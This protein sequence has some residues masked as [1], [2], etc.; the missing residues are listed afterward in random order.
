MRGS[1][2]GLC[3]CLVVAVDSVSFNLPTGARK[4]LSE[5]M[6]VNTL[7]M[8]GYSITPLDAANAQDSVVDV[9]LQDPLGTILYQKDSA[10]NGKFS[11]TSTREGSHEICFKNQGAEQE[12]VFLDFRSGV[13]AQDYE[14]MVKKDH[15]KPVEL[16]LTRLKDIVDGIKV[17]VAR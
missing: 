3:L 11:F 2:A 12:R 13:D 16:E 8:G 17:R 10:R 7:A 14:A 1:L 6:S 5:E 9:V 4:C 15:L